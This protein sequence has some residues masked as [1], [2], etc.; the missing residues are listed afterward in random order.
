MSA[1]RTSAATNRAIALRQEIV[2]IDQ[3]VPLLNGSTR[4]YIYL[5]NAASTP[6]FRGVQHKVDEFLGWYASVHRGAGFKSLLSTEAYE[7]AREIVA[8]FV[9]ADPQTHCVIFGKN[10]TEAINKLANRMALRPDDVVISTVMEHHSNDLP[11][12]PKAQIEYVGIRPDGSLDMDNL[13]QKL[14]RFNGRVKLVAVTGASN[15]SGFIPPIYDIAELAHEHGARILVDC[16]QLAPHRSINMGPIDSPQHLDFVSLS[17]HKMYAPFGTGALVGPKAFFQEGPPDYR[18]GG[19][20]S[21]VTLDEVHWTEPPERDEAGSPNVVGAVALAA[22]I[23]TLSQVGMDAIAA[24]E[25]ELTSYVLSRLNRLAGVRV[26]GSHDPDRLDDRLGVIAFEVDGIYHGKVAAILGFEGG[27]GVRD[28]CFC[29]HPYVLELVGISDASHDDYKRRILAGD[30]SDLPGM[31]R[32]S[33]GC[34]NTLE[35]IDALVEM[36]ERIIAGDYQGNY[37]VDKATGFYWPQ[38]FDLD[39][40]KDYFVL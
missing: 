12:R 6:T 4:P 39:I 38:G 35:E 23:R 2:G 13:Q 37:V 10:T 32:V 30:R 8:R 20:V 16:A 33:F 34:Y 18:G 25:M 9:G 36:L 14:D 40:L 19:T 22:S 21:I 3:A 29:A 1:H 28:G 11:W 24:H 27:I 17:A 31:V 26:Y 7:Q 5:D 15:V